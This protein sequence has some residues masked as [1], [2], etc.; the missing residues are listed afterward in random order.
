MNEK[1]I[2]YG[3]Q[4]SG[5]NIL[6]TLWNNNFNKKIIVY[7]DDYKYP[8]HKHYRLYKTYVN[9]ND[10]D[11]DVKAVL[12]IPQNTKMNY[13]IM[14]KE[15]YSWLVSYKKWAIKCKWENVTIEHMMYEYNNFYNMWIKW[16]ENNKNIYILN[17]NLI[18]LNQIKLMQSLAA[19]FK[20]LFLS[21][22]LIVPKSIPKTGIFNQERR[23][24]YINKLYMN[25]LTEEEKEIIQTSLMDSIRSFIN[26]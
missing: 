26:V 10:F 23:D 20:L 1:Y 11:R 14:I 17:Y 5:T 4:R 19:T 18:L 25:D 21:N 7:E 12:K 6:E 16:R 9:Y 8:T 15:P 2:L 22:K 24:Y 13:I 3:I